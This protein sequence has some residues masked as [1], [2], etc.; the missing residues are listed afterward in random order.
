MGDGKLVLSRT[1]GEPYVFTFGKSQH[2]D[3]NVRFSVTLGNTN[4]NSNAAAELRNQSSTGISPK[5][6]AKS[7]SFNRCRRH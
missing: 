2:N 3:N 4:T 1:E 5:G 7:E 6:E